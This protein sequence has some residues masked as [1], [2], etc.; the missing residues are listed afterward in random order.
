[1]SSNTITIWAGVVTQE[2]ELKST[3][4]G[5]S[6]LVLN[7]GTTKRWKDKDGNRQE[8]RCYFELKLWGKDAEEAFGKAQKL[9][10]VFC[11]GSLEL[12]TWESQGQK[13][14]KHV[15][16]PDF[17]VWESLRIFPP[18]EW[19]GEGQTSSAPADD[20]DIPF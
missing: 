15:V 12:E 4:S 11:R 1:M 13:R 16:V 3:Q 20:S 7:I 18:E 14:S 8:K 19:K 6:Y 10:V 5:K 2:P 9:G 17:P